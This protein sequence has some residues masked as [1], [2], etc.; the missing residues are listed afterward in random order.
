MQLQSVSKS[1]NE[2]TQNWVVTEESN[3]FSI[4]LF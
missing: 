4:I 2:K 3:K 1:F